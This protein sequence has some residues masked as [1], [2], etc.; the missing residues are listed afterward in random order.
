MKRIPIS[1]LLVFS[2]AACGSSGSDDA[3]PS[4]PEEVETQGEATEVVE[5]PE[6]VQ[7]AATAPSSFLQ[8]KTCHSTEKGGPN[9]LGPNLWSIAGAAAAQKSGFAY[10]P[11][12]KESGKTW[13][14]A[15]LD[16]YLTNP[17]KDVP[18]TKMVFAGLKNEVQRKEVIAYLNTLH[19]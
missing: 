9:G 3:L 14:D 15:T 19:D 11:A 6:A 5:A 18:G 7:T 10:S 12:M 8:C 16:T 13:D 1:T 17:L 4:V 2:L